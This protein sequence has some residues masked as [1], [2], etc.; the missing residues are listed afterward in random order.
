MQMIDVDYKL[1]KMRYRDTAPLTQAASN[2]KTL[3]L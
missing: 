3:Y 1:F 2:F